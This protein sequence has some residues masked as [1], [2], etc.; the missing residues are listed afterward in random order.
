MNGRKDELYESKS[1]LH[2]GVIT[3]IKFRPESKMLATCSHDTL[4]KLWDWSFPENMCVKKFRGHRDRVMSLDF[5]PQAAV[6]L[7]ASCDSKS[8]IKVWDVLKG[9]CKRSFKGGSRVVRIERNAGRTMAAA[10]GNVVNLFDIE[11]GLRT[12]ELKGHGLDVVGICWDRSGRQ[13]A[14]VSEDSVRVWSGT[15]ECVRACHCNGTTRFKTCTFHPVDPY[16]LI[17]G[18]HRVCIYICV[19]IYRLF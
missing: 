5:H 16:L 10:A 12:Q 9:V 8:W 2:D 15:G 1:K 18:S 7:L 4:I 11:T 3:D 6:N 17:L 14:S 19:Y 13:L